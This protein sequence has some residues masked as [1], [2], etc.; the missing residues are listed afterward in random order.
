MRYYPALYLMLILAAVANAGE[1][2]GIIY[3]SSEELEG[4]PEIGPK[5]AESL[6]A[7]FDREESKEL[8]ARLKALGVRTERS[9]E[10]AVGGSELQGISFVFTGKL[11]QMTREEAE[12]LVEQLGG[13]ATSS[14]SE[15]TDYVV[16]GPGA[17]SKLEKARQLGVEVLSEDEFVGMVKQSGG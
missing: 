13:R 15:S 14:V 11:E 2:D 17:G 8:V 6:R 1:I 16:A 3:E 10:E 4:V 5:I 7:Y 12:E 9:E